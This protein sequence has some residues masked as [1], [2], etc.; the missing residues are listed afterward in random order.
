[1]CSSDL[2][3]DGRGGAVFGGGEIIIVF[4][5]SQVAGFGLGGRGK[6]SKRGMCVA[7]DFVD[8]EFRDFSSG[9]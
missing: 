1:M 9:D 3:N 8:E 2:G 5:K 6:A 7:D 4:R